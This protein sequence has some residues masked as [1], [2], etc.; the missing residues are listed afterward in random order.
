MKLAVRKLAGHAHWDYIMS[1]KEAV[2]RGDCFVTSFWDKDDIIH[3][4]EELDIELTGEQVENIKYSLINN[5]DANV[6][7]NWDV[8]DHYIYEEDAVTYKEVA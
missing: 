6:G 5:H 7:T 2:L 1:R 4:S 3:R 8:I